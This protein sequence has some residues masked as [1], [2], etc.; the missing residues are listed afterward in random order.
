MNFSNIFVDRRKLKLSKEEYIINWNDNTLYAHTIL[1]TQFSFKLLQNTG[2]ETNFICEFHELLLSVFK[3]SDIF[4]KLW[5]YH[6]L[7]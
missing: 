1:V 7:L 5:I 6:I 2:K 3:S 4:T